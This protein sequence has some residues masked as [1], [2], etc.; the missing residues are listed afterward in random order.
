MKYIDLHLHSFYSDG[1]Y[2]PQELIKKA[3]KNGFSVISLTDH[4]CLDGI[5]E[6]ID[7][8]KKFGIK[9]I[10]GVEIYT[11][12]RNY[13]LHILGY[14]FDPKDKKINLFFKENQIKHAQRV[15]QYLKEIEKDGWII[16][17]RKDK[18]L[19][20]YL[21]ISWIVELI[22]DNP[23]NFKK[24]RKDF[25]NKEIITSGEILKRYFLESAQ[26][27]WQKSEIFLPTAIDLIKKA[28]GLVVLAHPVQQLSWRDD[29]LF[30]ILKKKG[31]DGIEAISSHHNWANI[32]HYQ[33]IAKELGFLVS[34][35]SDF[36]G[37]LPE[38]WG[39]PIR[40]LWQ[41]FKIGIDKEIKKLLSKI[42][43]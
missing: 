24:I 5:K 29:W 10:P 43:R 12:F 15:A 42:K 6:A 26:K 33:K 37:D 2:S 25:K 31:L 11:F 9:V 40:S 35:G 22:K 21:G 16:E 20:S 4:H 1:I 34:I 13:H 28:G 8:G 39:F 36:H 17:K 14:N 18:F 27:I 7:F 32:E 23:I 3:K 19:P 41:Y 38:E 30:P